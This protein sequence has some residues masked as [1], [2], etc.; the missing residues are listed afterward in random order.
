M[1]NKYGSSM[2]NIFN[3]PQGKKIM[4]KKND[5][6]KLVSSS[7]GQKIKAMLENKGDLMAAAQNGDIQTLQKTLSDILN[8]EEGARLAK[9]LSNMME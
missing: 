1:Q 7:D 3:S 8:T 2:G 4:S 6:E 5:L 9:K